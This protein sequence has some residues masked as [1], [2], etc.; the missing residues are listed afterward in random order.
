[1]D[2]RT[3][4]INEVRDVM[5]RVNILSPCLEVIGCVLLPSLT[6]VF[7]SLKRE[8]GICNFKDYSSGTQHFL[9]WLLAQFR[10]NLFLRQRFFIRPP[11]TGPWPLTTHY[12]PV[13]WLSVPKMAKSGPLRLATSLLGR[14]RAWLTCC[15][16]SRRPFPTAQCIWAIPPIALSHVTV[17]E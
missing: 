12:S 15:L 1:M 6:S 16:F 13:P 9:T 3:A 11:C 7:S 2:T 5:L 14:V 4:Q 10:L 8:S 17:T